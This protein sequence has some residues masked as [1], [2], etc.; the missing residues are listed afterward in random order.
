MGFCSVFVYDGILL[1][2]VFWF[3]NSSE[4]DKIKANDQ[5]VPVNLNTHFPSM[6]TVVWELETMIL[7]T[8]LGKGR[9]Q[10]SLS[11]SLSYIEQER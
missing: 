5:W 4:K 6:T 2:L 7:S 8:T 3:F 10:L 9:N 1:V 11:L